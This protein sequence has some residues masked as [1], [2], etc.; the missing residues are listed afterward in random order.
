[1]VSSLAFSS[2]VLHSS[3][4]AATEWRCEQAKAAIP[5]AHEVHDDTAADRDIH[6]VEGRVGPR[7]GAIRG[8]SLRTDTHAPKEDIGSSSEEQGSRSLARKL[9]VLPA[10]RRALV[11]GEIGFCM[12]QVIAK[13]AR[14]DDEEQWV[15]EA[16]RRTVREMRA[17]LRDGM[18]PEPVF[19]AADEPRVTLAVTVDREDGWLFEHARLLGKHAGTPGSD[20]LD[21][22][23]AEGTTS[24]LAEVERSVVESFDGTLDEQRHSARGSRSW[25]GFARRRRGSARHGLPRD[26]ASCLARRGPAS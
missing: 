17:L 21:A 9:A 25:R 2:A 7:S 5:F 4:V 20:I 18:G 24:L 16:R 12:A 3:R 13:V 22:L 19:A 10:I 26:L 8:P 23:L 15:E 1:M 11:R 6:V 14:A